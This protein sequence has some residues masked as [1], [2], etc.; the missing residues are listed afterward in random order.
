MWCGSCKGIFNDYATATIQESS[1]VANAHWWRIECTM[2][3]YT[4]TNS[5]EAEINGTFFG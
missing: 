4:D 3:K 2:V 1:K 5:S